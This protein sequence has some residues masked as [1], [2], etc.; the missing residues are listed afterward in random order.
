MNPIK[1]AFAISRIPVLDEL[2][3]S[4]SKCVDAKI[5]VSINAILSKAV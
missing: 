1:S 5:F 2:P 3:N 4:F